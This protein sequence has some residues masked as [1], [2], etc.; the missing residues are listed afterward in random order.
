MS[1]RAFC[2][3]FLLFFL[4]VPA[5]CI[6]AEEPAG[7]EETKRA[8]L[9]QSKEAVEDLLMFWEEKDLFVQTAT[10]HNKA[11]SQVAENITIISAK[12]IEDMNA[13]TTAEVLNRVTGLFVDFG[14]QDFGSISFLHIQSSIHPS[15]PERH[16]LVL[17]D[18]VEWNLLNGGAAE[19][20]SIPVGIISRI[21]AI[22]GPASSSWGSSLGGVINIIT[23]NAG[24]KARP[25]GGLSASYGEGESQDYRADLSGKAG[26]LGYYFF[27][28]R[29]ISDGLRNNRAFDNYS[30]YAKLR[31]PVSKS[32]NLGVTAGYSDPHLTSFEFPPPVD[33]T[34]RLFFRTFFVTANLDAVLSPELSLDV[35]LR[36]FSQK[37]GVLN[38]VLTTGDMIFHNIADE[39]TTAGSAK[40][41]WKSG[42]NAIVLGVDA[43]HGRSDQTLEGMFNAAAHS[44]VDKWAI[45]ANDTISLGKLSITPGI[46]Y[47]YN[48]ITGSFTSPSLG[49]TYRMAGRTILR[50]SVARGFTVPP[51]GWTSGGGYYLDPNPDIK[52]ESV[53]SYQAGIESG[54]GEY[55]WMKA[56]AFYDDMKDGIVKELFAGHWIPGCIGTDSDCRYDLMRNNGSIRRHGA[57]L[58][59]ET[60]P[61]HNFSL[62]AGLAYVKT[63]PH[64]DDANSTFGRS[65]YEYNVG[66]KYDNA[67]KF[68]AEL[69]GHYVWWDLNDPLGN[70]PKYNSFVWDFNA[71]KKIFKSENRVAEIFLTG[72][73]IFNGS[74]YTLS[75]VK[76]PG[77]WIEAGVRYSF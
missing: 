42:S 58:E 5:I 68:T 74:Q 46:R 11:V 62:K 51:L 26:P 53:W 66:L 65:T 10:R 37:P 4:S 50:A 27:A 70:L 63:T 7:L 45:F 23:K 24:D 1:V 31:M 28:G 38:D 21:E 36:T 19:T 17:L 69:F 57:E 20:N 75:V 54:I 30:L 25:A 32:V 39:R 73:N 56:T 13:H 15:F 71:R 40:L 52:S 44:G 2:I 3:C 76:N 33:Y 48:N 16:V 22:K 67:G 9:A 29:Q 47:D 49:V 59:A 6:S 35:S 61:F 43:G 8:V 34:S 14:G 18:G 64:P 72:H 12:E 55:V 77:R 60:A 41:V